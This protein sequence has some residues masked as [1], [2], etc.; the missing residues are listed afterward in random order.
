MKAVA[1]FA[2]SLLF[3]VTA[4]HADC[5]SDF[6]A[7]MEA[8]RNGGPYHI[9]TAMTLGA[10][11]RKLVAEFILPDKLHIFQDFTQHEF[12]ITPKGAWTKVD[13]KW[14]V[15]DSKK[16]DEI[17]ATKDVSLSS[18]FK[19]A[20]NVQCKGKQNIEGQSLNAYA[21]DLVNTAQNNIHIQEM[22]YVDEKNL[23]LILTSEFEINGRKIKTLM[24]VTR[25][26]AITIDEPTSGEATIT[27]KAPDAACRAEMKIITDAVSTAGPQRYA[28][29][30]HSGSAP[31]NI[32]FE[33]VPGTAMRM[34]WEG[35]EQV[36]TQKGGWMKG[37]ASWSPLPPNQY[38]E[39]KLELQNP[40]WSDVEKLTNLQ[41][42]GAQNFESKNY[43]AFSFG[44]QPFLGAKALQHIKLYVG[45]D[46]RP[47]AFS[48]YKDGDAADKALV[49]HVAFD[50]AIK[51]EAPQ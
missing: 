26:P 42:L 7:A 50:K 34:A 32:T 36:I 2:T 4:A 25:N 28:M 51:I 33:L 41:C 29:V 22:A 30:D 39:A 18:G 47:V 5:L 14:N 44:V 24:H 15:L 46:N 45:D 31:M 17:L 37:G 8:H 23:P 20:Q 35:G 6:S 21:F 10:E 27:T 3:S 9:E 48:D 40:W 38:A 13:G 11:T 19:A 12:L 1:L 16:R 49:A 43:K